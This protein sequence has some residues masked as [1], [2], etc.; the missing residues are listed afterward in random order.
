MKKYCF[1]LKG[2]MYDI[3]FPNNLIT[4]RE[5]LL[6]I[7]MEACR[8]MMYSDEDTH[9][10]NKMVLLV[11]EMNRLFFCSNKKYYS[12]A[13][14]FHVAKNQS[15]IFDYQG[16]IIDSQMIS[17]ICL[18]LGADEYKSFHAIDFVGLIDDIENNHS[19]DFWHVFKHLLTYEI[20]YVRY[21]N[22]IEGYKNALQRGKPKSH[23]HYHLD[24]NMSN[25]ATYK[26]GLPNSYSL[27][28]F[29][30]ILDNDNN[31]RLFMKR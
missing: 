14:P 31:D 29:I 20:G 21:D 23:P 7:I 30:Y 24:I 3:A 16:V 13:F 9:T 6:R 19:E 10:Q 4:E 8:Q 22:D 5:Q 25:Q 1:E 27:D 28:D 12:V 18:I 11:K 17:D 26:V 15:L 2:A